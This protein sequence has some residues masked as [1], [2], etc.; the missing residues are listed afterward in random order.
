MI[1]IAL[2]HAHMEAVQCHNFPDR[3]D[4]TA[5]PTRYPAPNCRFTALPQ[6]RVIHAFIISFSV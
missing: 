1:R 3:A 5:L 6:R 2:R 4:G